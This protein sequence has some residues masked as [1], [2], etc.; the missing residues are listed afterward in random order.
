MNSPFH[1]YAALVARQLAAIQADDFALLESL[2]DERDAIAVTLADDDAPAD[3]ETLAA[4]LEAR[5]MEQELIRQLRLRRDE[6]FGLIRSE[7]ARAARLEAY[8]RAA[9]RLDRESVD[10]SL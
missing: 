9:V 2:A 3:T 10:F 8:A 6:L 5:R 4:A 7:P 1:R